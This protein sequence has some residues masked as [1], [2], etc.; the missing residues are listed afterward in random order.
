MFK[1]KN[2]AEEDYLAHVKDKASARQAKQSGKELCMAENSKTLVL[3]MDLQALLLCPRLEASALFYKSK[4][5]VHNF[6]L[7]NLCDHSVVCYVWH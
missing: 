4:L 2:L 5:G 3:T 1:T 6:T 7:F